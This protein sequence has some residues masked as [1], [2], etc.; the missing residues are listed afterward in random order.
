MDAGISIT[1]GRIAISPGDAVP[2][3]VWKT[4]ET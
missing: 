1:E 2:A 4:T 3:L